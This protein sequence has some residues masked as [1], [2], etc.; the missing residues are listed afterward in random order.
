MCDEKKKMLEEVFDSYDADKSGKIDQ[1]ELKAAV[2]DYY[3]AQNLTVDEGQLEADAAGIIAACDTS[4]DG[5]IDK[6]EWFKFFNC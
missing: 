2:K 1:K 5:K 4:N 6:A 3:K